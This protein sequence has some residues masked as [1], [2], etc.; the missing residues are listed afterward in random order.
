MPNRNSKNN[1]AKNY[2]NNKNFQGNK[3]NTP[4]NQNNSKGK[5]FANNHGNFTKSFEH[6]KPIKCWEC[7]GPHYASVCPNRKKTGN[8][9]HTIHDEMTVGELARTMPRINVALE[10]RQ[11]EYHTSMVE[12]EGMINQIHVTILIDLGASISYIAPQIVEK[13]KLYVDKF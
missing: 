8:N 7:N 10:N 6:K 5:D 4:N 11:A 13:R 2:P 1:K 9:I 12:V 3:N